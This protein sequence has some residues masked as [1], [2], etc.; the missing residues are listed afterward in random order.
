MSALSAEWADGHL[1]RWPSSS[2][3]PAAGP[4]HG[5]RAGRC[6]G[7][8]CKADVWDA[9]T[10]FGSHDGLRMTALTPHT[11]HRLTLPEGTNTPRGTS[12]RPLDRATWS[13]VSSWAII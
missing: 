13:T 6:A 5:R 3:R 2:E 4:D 11:P 7:P 9:M 10:D 1:R 8:A 12:S